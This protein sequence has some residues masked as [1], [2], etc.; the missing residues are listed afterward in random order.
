[1]TSQ[2]DPTVEGVDSVA[3]IARII[4]TYYNTLILSG[5]PNGLAFTLTCQ[6]QAI[7]LGG[8][9]DDQPTVYLGAMPIDDTSDAA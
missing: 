7:T 2:P 9:S 6:Y 8:G 5:I 4:A 3:V 1:M